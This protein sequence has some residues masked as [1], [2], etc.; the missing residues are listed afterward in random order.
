ML[1][2]RLL[3]NYNDLCSVISGIRLIGGGVSSSTEVR[4]LTFVEILTQLAGGSSV[5]RLASRGQSENRSKH[6][7]WQHLCVAECVHTRGP[8]PLARLLTFTAT[9]GVPATMEPTTL[10]RATLS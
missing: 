5:V 9:L 7:T 2:R 3:A 10:L 8:L 6:Q 1:V 4:R